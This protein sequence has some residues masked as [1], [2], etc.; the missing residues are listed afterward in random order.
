MVVVDQGFELTRRLRGHL[1]A[2]EASAEFIENDENVA[3]IPQRLLHGYVER[4]PGRR[5]P[6]TV[7]VPPV[8]I[9]GSCLDGVAIKSAAGLGRRRSKR[10]NRAPRPSSG[11]RCGGERRQADDCGGGA[12]GGDRR[13]HVEDN[14]RHQPDVRE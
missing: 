10:D 2:V 5:F 6:L 7:T 4:S 14:T 12:E 11:W 13:M 8:V 1:R 3:A 9:F